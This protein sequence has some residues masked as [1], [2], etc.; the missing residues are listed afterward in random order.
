ML[1]VNLLPLLS[2]SAPFSAFIRAVEERT[3]DPAGVYL[4]G[5]NMKGKVQNA[6]GGGSKPSRVRSMLSLIRKRRATGA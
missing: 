1:A 3:E 5:L 2:L 4:G 6:A